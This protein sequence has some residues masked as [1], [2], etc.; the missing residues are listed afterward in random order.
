MPFHSCVTSPHNGQQQRRRTSAVP[1]RIHVAP[2]CFSSSLSATL[3][4]SAPPHSHNAPSSIAQHNLATVSNL[5][6]SGGG[7]GTAMRSLADDRASGLSSFL[8]RAQQLE[9]KLLR[10]RTSALARDISKVLDEYECL[11]S[12]CKDASK[13]PV[14]SMRDC[15]CAPKTDSCCVGANNSIRSTFWSTGCSVVQLVEEARQ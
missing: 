10:Q 13:H 2:G 11:D 4:G 3:S 15:D 12:V 6:V 5:Q 8:S 7:A 9:S 14:C 1:T